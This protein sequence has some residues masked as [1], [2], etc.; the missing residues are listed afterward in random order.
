MGAPVPGPVLGARPG[1]VCLPYSVV[2]VHDPVD[3]VQAP[4]DRLCGG[5]VPAAA[6]C[7]DLPAQGFLWLP[8]PNARVAGSVFHPAGH[9][10]F[11]EAE[12]V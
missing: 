2:P 6:E 3:R 12:M 7:V 1:P 8:D 11:P 10:T 5:V 9:V 4:G